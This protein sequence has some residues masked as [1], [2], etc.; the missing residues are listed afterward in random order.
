MRKIDSDT[1]KMDNVVNETTEEVNHNTNGR[2]IEE[3]YAIEAQNTSEID[4]NKNQSNEEEMADEK[5]KNAHTSHTLHTTKN[6]NRD[7]SNAESVCETLKVVEKTLNAWMKEDDNIIVVDKHDKKM[8]MNE[9]W[10]CGIRTTGQN[11]KIKRKLSC[12]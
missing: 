8:R 5:H 10:A 4:R 2:N 3:M 6:A 11:K 9:N 7:C 12:L 1:T